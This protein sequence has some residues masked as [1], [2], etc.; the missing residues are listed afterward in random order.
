MLPKDS[1]NGCTNWEK[2][3]N[4]ENVALGLPE[5][6][7]KKKKH[8]YYSSFHLSSFIAIIP[9]QLHCSTG[10]QKITDLGE[11]HRN[12]IQFMEFIHTAL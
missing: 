6:Q 7:K 10:T 12:F 11:K 9:F 8:E 5:K 1:T 2:D 3:E 4:W